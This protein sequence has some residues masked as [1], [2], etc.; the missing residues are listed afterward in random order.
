VRVVTGRCDEK[1]QS[2]RVWGNPA[3]SFGE[4][5][6]GQPVTVGWWRPHRGPLL[7]EREKGRT[8]SC[9]TSTIQ[10]TRVTLPALNGAHPPVRVHLVHVFHPNGH[11]DALVA[12]FVSVLLKSGDA[13]AAAAAS[14]RP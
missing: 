5:A 11:P 12:P 10:E 9:F 2:G 13:R 3:F 4:A 1:C 14:L 7:K 6:Y 8:P